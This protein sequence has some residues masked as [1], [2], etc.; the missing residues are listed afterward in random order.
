MHTADTPS[1]LLPPAGEKQ[2]QMIID[3]I[4]RLERAAQESINERLEQLGDKAFRSCA[5]SIRP[6]SSSAVTNAF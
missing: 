4:S 3:E 2:P 1:F 6:V 5:L